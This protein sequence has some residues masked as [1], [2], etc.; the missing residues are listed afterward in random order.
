MG[1]RSDYMEQTDEEKHFQETAKLILYVLEELGINHLLIDGTS[2][3]RYKWIHK[4]S[5]DQY[6]NDRDLEPYLCNLLRNMGETDLEE[7]VYNAKS[8]KSRQL[9][10]WWED[11]QKADEARKK[12]D[13]NKLED[14]KIK[15]S[16]LKK[17][18]A[19]EKRVLNIK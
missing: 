9:A 4:Q 19:E 15:E 12:I 11:H 18:T 5:V 16:A 14:Q 13:L 7:I 8:R 2:V 3:E 6:A 10:D 1:C 17:L